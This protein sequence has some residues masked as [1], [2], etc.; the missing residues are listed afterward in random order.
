M[1]SVVIGAHLERDDV[2][3][4]ATAIAC[5]G[6]WLSGVDVADD[7]PLGDR[8]LLLRVAGVRATLLERATFIAI[9]YGF[10][11][12]P[13]E[14]A[15]KCAEHAPRWRRVLE[16]NRDNV[17]MTLKVVSA[18]PKPRPDHRDFAKGAD[19]L[20]ALR[21]SAAEADPKFRDAVSRLGEHRWTHR[22]GRSLECALLVPRAEV[23]R[24]RAAGERLKNEFPDVP[25][26]L[27]GPWPLEVFADHE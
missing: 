6:V 5:G 8:D 24:V 25:F 4:L 21:A 15:A 13:A 14:A 22:D 17:E 12:T 7:Q 1:K 2:E 20:K 27:S 9:R 10:A 19:Y 16:A 11:A 3:P 23:E 26:L 18:E